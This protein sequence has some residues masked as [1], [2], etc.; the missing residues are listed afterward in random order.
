MQ[1]KTH[2]PTFKGKGG[3][4]QTPCTI[5]KSIS[6]SHQ[7]PT[8]NGKV[9]SSQYGMAGKSILRLYRTYCGMFQGWTNG[10]ERETSRWF[11]YEQAQEYRKLKG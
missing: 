3:G 9:P 10:G 6:M 7:G 4:T 5:Y 11:W 2:L 8:S 1:V